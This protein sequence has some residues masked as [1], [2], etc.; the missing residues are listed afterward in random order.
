MMRISTYAHNS[1]IS[2]PSSEPHSFR[3]DGAE[4]R[5]LE[6]NNATG[7]FVFEVV[8]DGRQLQFRTNQETVA[9]NWVNWV[10]A[11]SNEKRF[12]DTLRQFITTGRQG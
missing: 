12:Q 9:E 11:C 1:S 10:I 4:A 3:L 7:E 8:A 6:K 5:I 2:D